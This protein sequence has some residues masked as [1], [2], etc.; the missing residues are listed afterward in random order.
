LPPR[1]TEDIPRGDFGICEREHK[2]EGKDGKDG[3]GREGEDGKEGKVG[4]DGKV[5]GVGRGS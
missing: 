2:R 5:A 1:W 3:K 4:K